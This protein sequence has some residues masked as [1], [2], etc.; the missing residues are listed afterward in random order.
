M[1]C[2]NQPVE[3]LKY[4]LFFTGGT[5]F[6]GK[7][8]LRRW[9][10]R[11]DLGAAMPEITVLSR[12][13]N[14]FYEKCPEFSNLS[15]LSLVKGD[16]LNPDSFPWHKSFD[17][18]LHAATDSTRGPQL[19][20]IARY[21]QIVDGTRNL[22]DFVVKKQVPRFLLVSSGA[23]YGPQPLDL[24]YLP[25]DY[26]GGADP[27]VPSNAYSVAKRCAEH[28]CALYREKFDLDIAIARCFAFVGRDLPL[29]AH[30]AIGNFIRDAL[31]M[32]Y[33][34]VRGDGSQ[35]RSYMDQ[36]DLA[37]WLENLLLHGRSGCAYNVGSDQEISIG[38][39]ADLVRDVLAPG[40]PV[41]F[42]QEP[43][44]GFRNRYVPDI[45]RARAE[46]GLELTISLSDAI[47]RVGRHTLG[48]SQDRQ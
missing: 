3:R 19:G 10:I 5:G 35:I 16:I 18:V 42:Q 22:L 21:D 25:E 26:L 32:P 31:A 7:S 39:L 38:G 45:S 2:R 12:D 30:F 48:V 23:V 44:D 15:W 33:I 28:L 36:Q 29:D 11:S 8:L 27:L 20:L 17:L 14:G 9:V 6:F 24:A 37:A 41:V 43:A 47:R 13:P 40:K 46:L 4:R 1:L 34:S